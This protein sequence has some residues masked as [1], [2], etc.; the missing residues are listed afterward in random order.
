MKCIMEIK[1]INTDKL[2]NIDTG[3]RPESFDSFV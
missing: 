1:K 2:I 3:F